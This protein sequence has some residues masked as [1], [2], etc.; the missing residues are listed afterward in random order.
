MRSAL[1]FL[2][3]FVA[4]VALLVI[5]GTFVPRPLFQEAAAEGP[6]PHRIL[7]LSN[8]IHT[9]IAIPID[10]R[11]LETFSFLARDG[12]PIDAP[13]ARYL[14]FGWGGRSFYIETPTWSELK[15]LP[16]LK[17]LTADSAAMHVELA[18][19]IDARHPSVATYAIGEREFAQLLAYIRASFRDEAGGPEIIA[20]AGYGEFDR[21]YEAHGTF[22]ALLGCNTWTAAALRNAGLRTGWWT[23]LPPLLGTS[24]RLYN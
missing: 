18:G 16:L 24:M 5:A 1:R 12:L 14:T 8:P 21:F 9:D 3:W 23:P 15:A 7:V 20:G 19:Q 13:Q 17:G 6:K 22:T 11:V 4:A 2:F 10:S